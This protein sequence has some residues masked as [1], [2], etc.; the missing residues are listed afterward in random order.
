MPDDRSAGNAPMPPHFPLLRRLSIVSLLAMLVTAALLILLY[1]QDQ[2]EEHKELAAQENERT[3]MHLIQL[4]GGQINAYMSATAG[5]DAQAVRANPAIDAF[6]ATLHTVREHSILKLKLYNTSGIAV[7]S[8]ILSDIGGTS[9]NRAVLEK[10]LASE[11]QHKLEF[12]D[13]FGTTA[14]NTRDRHILATYVP[15][16]HA[17]KRIGVLE[18][19]ADITPAFERI[20]AKIT[21]IALI[22]IGVFAA[23]YI[24]LFFSA[25]KADQEIAEDTRK[26]AES[27][28]RLWTMVDSALDAIVSID[29]ESRL[30]AFNPAAEAMFGWNRKEVI[31]H[32]MVDMVIP[33]RYRELH[34][35]GLS[36]YMQTGE[37]HIL[38]RRIE[39][40]ALRRDGAEFP[41]ELTVAPIREGDRIIFTAFIRDIAERKRVE[42]ERREALQRLQMITSQVPGV[43]YQF[44][45]RPDGSYCLPFASDA[46]REI[47]RVEPDEIREDASKLFA[48]I[49]PD[50]YD[51]IFASIAASASGL[52]PWHHEF[53][54]KF[55]DGTVR[56]LQG[57]SIPQREA[58]GSTL[59]HGFVTDISARK[60]S[61][62]ALRQSETKFSTLF[63]STSDA[64]ML[65]DE[66]GFFD[67]NRAALAAFGCATKEEFCSKHPADLS[68]PEQPCGTNSLVLA[69]RQ[70]AAA[71]E[72][73][74]H[75][76][77]W[78]H[79]RADTGET[80]QPKCCSIP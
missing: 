25:R 21:Q 53:R 40:T 37:S 74:S 23:L 80:F 64:V 38:S 33:E 41:I 59:W 24:G 4:M 71:L 10:A 63:N 56:W 69:N 68:P 57:D 49:H 12:R 65:L 35:K 36:R 6:N 26:L 14:G 78:V 3:A 2:L 20:H 50:D 67:C 29:A 75:R 8:T 60:Q 54:T 34:L 32:S 11:T 15:L 7:F 52:T 5:L 39:I 18:I 44:R 77:E 70:I 73:G 72:K 58:D 19:Y 66:R 48:M 79:K 47:F 61:E 46:V 45:L 9:R 55:G 1:R 22:I 51:R 13:T 17:E 31:G 42:E 27:E 76:F 62:E 16:F 30:I 43:V 28:T